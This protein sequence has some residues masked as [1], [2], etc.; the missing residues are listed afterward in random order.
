MVALIYFDMGTCYYIFEQNKTKSK[1]N[2]Q[3]IW[4]KWGND[5]NS[6]ICI[7]LSTVQEMFCWKSKKKKKKINI[8]YLPYFY[9][10]VSVQNVLLFLLNLKLDWIS[11]LISSFQACAKRRAQIIFW[12]NP[13]YTVWSSTVTP[14]YSTIF[15]SVCIRVQ[16]LKY[17]KIWILITIPNFHVCEWA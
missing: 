4:K 6:L 12:S 8:S 13:G 11:P 9:I 14:G 5:I 10:K 3:N 16:V 17:L 15:L 2:I 1:S 7:F